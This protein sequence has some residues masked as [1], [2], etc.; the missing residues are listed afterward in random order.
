[1]GRKFDRV[2]W[3][4]EGQRHSIE[5]HDLELF[6]VNLQVGVKVRRGVHDSPELTLSGSDGDSR[7]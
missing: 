6:P 4:V 5:G 7:A 2:R 3:I 1:M